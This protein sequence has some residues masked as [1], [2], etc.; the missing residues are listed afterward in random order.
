MKVRKELLIYDKLPLKFSFSFYAV[1]ARLIKHTTDVHMWNNNSKT[2]FLNVLIQSRSVCHNP[3]GYRL[4]CLHLIPSHHSWSCLHTLSEVWDSGA[5]FPPFRITHL[6]P[7]F[8]QTGWK[9]TSTE[10]DNASITGDM[11]PKCL[12]YFLECYQCTM[13]LWCSSPV[14]HLTPTGSSRTSCLCSVFIIN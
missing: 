1:E 6:L 14:Q 2:L 5:C 10:R 11:K 9:T 4:Y 12:L 8:S 13:M 3:L 7:F